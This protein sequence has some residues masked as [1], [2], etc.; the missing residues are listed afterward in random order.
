[1]HAY[2]HTHRTSL[3]F[4]A[5]SLDENDTRELVQIVSQVKPL[6]EGEIPTEPGF[7]FGRAMIKD[8]LLASQL[9]RVTMF[10]SIK[11]HPDFL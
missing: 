10:L 11:E 8:P 7:C 3:D 5:K 2:V 1:M 9:E 4:S 6:T